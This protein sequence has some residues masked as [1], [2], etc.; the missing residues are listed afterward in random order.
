MDVCHLWL[1][2]AIRWR[3]DAEAS[4]TV[5]LLS[6]AKLA[7]RKDSHAKHQPPF[8]GEDAATVD[9]PATSGQCVAP[10]DAPSGADHGSVHRRLLPRHKGESGDTG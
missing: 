9:K 2:V 10:S 8:R 3:A 5:A 1:G 6:D 7:I 4:R